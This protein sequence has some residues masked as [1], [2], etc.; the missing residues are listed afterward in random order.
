MYIYHASNVI[1]INADCFWHSD[2][3]LNTSH[4]SQHLR[5]CRFSLFSWTQSTP[6]SAFRLS[7]EH[8]AYH[9]QYCAIFLNTKHTN[10]SILPFTWTQSRPKVSSLPFYLTQSIPLSP[11]S[12]WEE[13]R[14]RSCPPT[15]LC[16]T[17]P[18][19]CPISCM[20][21]LRTFAKCLIHVLFQHLLNHLRVPGCVLS[22][23]FLRIW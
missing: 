7:T 22:H 23:L 4:C 19:H 14:S 6:Q 15:F 16:R 10:I 18:T 17:Y 9:I 20:K 5:H 3:L 11:M 12:S 8:K 1:I 13:R 2:I 21:R